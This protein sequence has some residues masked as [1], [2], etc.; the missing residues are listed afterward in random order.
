MHK[1]HKPREGYWYYT[2]AMNFMF[3]IGCN[4]IERLI[5]RCEGA[6]KVFTSGVQL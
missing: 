2:S 3:A 5:Y 4:E 1:T 6:Y